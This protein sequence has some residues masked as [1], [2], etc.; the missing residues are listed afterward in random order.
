[1]INALGYFPIERKS[2]NP[3][4]ENSVT[5]KDV[6]NFLKIKEPVGIFPEG[7]TK[8]DVGEQ[9]GKFNTKLIQLAAKNDA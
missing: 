9:L 5:L 1:M 6:T 3:L 4:A 7:A 8:K 2:Y